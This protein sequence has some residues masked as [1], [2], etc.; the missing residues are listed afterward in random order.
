MRA[1]DGSYRWF[2]LRAVPLRDPTGV[3]IEWLA[4][5]TDISEI[6]AARG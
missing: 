2:L 1:A 4:T 3:V 6:V 5:S